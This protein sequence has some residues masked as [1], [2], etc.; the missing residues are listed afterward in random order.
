MHSSPHM[1]NS[2][3]EKQPKAVN[4]T[5]QDAMHVIR[6]AHRGG[7]SLSLACMQ[8][9]YLAQ[10]ISANAQYRTGGEAP[11]LGHS[12]WE[13]QETRRQHNQARCHK[14][15]QPNAAG[16]LPGSRFAPSALQSCIF[17]F[18][19]LDLTCMPSCSL[20]RAPG[21]GGQMLSWSARGSQ[22]AL[23]GATV[24]PFWIHLVQSI[25]PHT[26]SFFP[27]RVCNAFYLFHTFYFFLLSLAPFMFSALFCCRMHAARQATIAA[28]SHRSIWLG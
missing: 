19:W 22:T 13:I 1:A 26:D 8:T 23:D 11:Q 20:A 3:T 21:S 16:R 15:G 24:W 17:G 4:S 7:I 28:W 18:L 14:N 27:V 10:I 25:D 2:E 12:R 6:N 5:R 9:T